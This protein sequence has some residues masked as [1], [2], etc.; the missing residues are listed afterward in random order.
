MKKAETDQE[1]LA[2]FYQEDD[3]SAL[4]TFVDRHRQWALAKARSYYPEEAEDIVQISILQLM[5][6]QPTRRTVASPLGWWGT[7]I[8]AVAVDQLRKRI[9]RREK[10]H[11]SAALSHID[12]HESEAEDSAFRQQLVARVHEA[13][14]QLDDR[15]KETL[16]KRYF[17]DLSYSEIAHILQISPGTVASRLARAIA[18]LRG[19]L[20]QRDILDLADS[21]KPYGEQTTMAA[22]SND[23]QNQNKHF[24]EKWNDIWLIAGGRGLGRYHAELNADGSVSASLRMDFPVSEDSYD[25]ARPESAPDRLW[26]ESELT[27]EDA[28]SFKWSHC[29]STEGATGKA[30]SRMLE[31]GMHYGEEHA[32]FFSEED[33]LS[34]HSNGN[35]KATLELPNGDAVVPDILSPLIVCELECDKRTERSINLLCFER[36]PTGRKWAIA[37]TRA[38]YAG[39]KGLPT[40]LSHTFEIELN[41]FTGRDLSI[42]VDND[43]HLIGLG[44]ERESFI[45][46]GDEATA[47][48]LLAR[49]FSN[50]IN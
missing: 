12:A 39:R 23:V 38:A 35:I 18:R 43:R 44:D 33:K 6:S 24:V 11:N 48:S 50:S 2:S 5:D 40:G 13:I 42:W 30:Y 25:R 49:E 28:R 16:L 1:L 36:L 9:T 32:L 26:F 27:L 4:E 10:E 22:I 34:V 20:V 45:V 29:R 46:A 8:G 7:I 17:D 14:D 21:L 19:F 41:S 3:D 47:R 15:F 37:S 31:K